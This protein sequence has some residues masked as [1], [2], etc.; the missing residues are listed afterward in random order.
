MNGRG[1]VTADEI[2]IGTHKNEESI[3]GAKVKVVA[4]AREICRRCW[5]EESGCDRFRF[6][7]RMSFLGG[8]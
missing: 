7:S 1:F 8:W 3:A 6:Y 5:K 4:A 2:E